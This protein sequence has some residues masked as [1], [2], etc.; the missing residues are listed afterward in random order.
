MG[1]KL[2]RI[3]NSNIKGVVLVVLSTI[4]WAMNG[5]VGSYLFKIRR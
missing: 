3:E 5:N 2:L 1:G 4:M